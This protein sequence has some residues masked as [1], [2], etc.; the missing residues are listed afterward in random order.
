MKY[1]KDFRKRIPREEIDILYKKIKRCLR[2]INHK[3]NVKTKFEIA[4]SYR[5][6]KATCG[7]IDIII[8]E[9]H[10]NILRDEIIAKLKK[11]GILID[12]LALGQKKYMGIAHIISDAP[13]RRVDIEWCLYSEYPSCLLYFT[14]S[15]DLNVKMRREAK[16]RGLVLNEHGLFENNKIIPFKKETEILTY[17]GFD[18]KYFDPKVR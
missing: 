15:A 2:H 12:D 6:G 5:R 3:F 17:L 16:K 1:Y 11:K 8:T 7:D 13:V 10:D 18:E 4:G 9:R 14:G